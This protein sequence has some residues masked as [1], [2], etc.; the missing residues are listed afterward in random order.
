M[1]FSFPEDAH[2]DA[3]RQAVEFGVE[4]GE[5]RGV[6]RARSACFNAYCRSGPLPSGASNHECIRR[7]LVRSSAASRPSPEQLRQEIR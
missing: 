5:H 4:I 3:E 7:D 2:W 1:F 6:V